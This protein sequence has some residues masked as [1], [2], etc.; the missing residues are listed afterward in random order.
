MYDYKNKEILQEIDIEEE[1]YCIDSKKGEDTI[2]L[3]GPTN[4]IE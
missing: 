3:A 1:Y 4:K 2:I